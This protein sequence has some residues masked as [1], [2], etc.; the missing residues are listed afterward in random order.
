[1]PELVRVSVMLTRG[2]SVKPSQLPE[3]L[4]RCL[5]VPAALPQHV[6]HVAVVIHRA[7]EGVAF[8]IAREEDLVQMPWIAWPRMPAAYLMGALLAA[9]AA[10]RANSFVRHDDPPNEEEFFHI[11]V[12]EWK[13]ARQPDRVADDC[14]REPMLL[15]GIRRVRRRH[16]SSTS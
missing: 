6:E 7:P 12:A 10:P 11:A 1:M 4:R 2:T 9:C 14:P 13:A 5:R 3:A 16:G 8:A 15:V